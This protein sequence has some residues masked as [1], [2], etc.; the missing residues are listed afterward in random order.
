MNWFNR[1]LH[2]AKGAI[3]GVSDPFIQEIGSQPTGYQS[4][5]EQMIKNIDE[6]VYGRW[7]N[8]MPELK[9]GEFR[10]EGEKLEDFFEQA[11]NNGLNE[12]MLFVAYLQYV[13]ADVYD[14]EKWSKNWMSRIQHRERIDFFPDHKGIFALL[15]RLEY[16][17][18]KV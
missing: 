3:F 12:T 17:G 4:L 11:K 13:K 7:L 14:R 15:D 18:E 1:Q 9:E 2:K 6:G 16:I 10:Q 8:G 5:F